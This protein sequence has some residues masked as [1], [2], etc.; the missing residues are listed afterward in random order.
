MITQNNNQDQFLG[1]F[2]EEKT[3]II[4]FLINGFQIKGVI[5]DFD[6]STVCLFSQEKQH[7]IYKHAISTFTI[8]DSE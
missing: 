4:V 1:R 7:L 6:E 8:D 5:E 2:K 3:N